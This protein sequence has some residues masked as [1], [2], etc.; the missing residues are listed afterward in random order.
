MPIDHPRRRAWLAGTL[1]AA[2]AGV[3]LATG[4]A[5]L[6]AQE[7]PARTITL[8]NPFPAGGGGDVLIRPL[9]GSSPT[10]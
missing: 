5:P 10:G 8:I 7:Y 6:R 1:R 2:G 3:A 4:A 9:A